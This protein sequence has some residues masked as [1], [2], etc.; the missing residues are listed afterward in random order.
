MD[1]RHENG[2]GNIPS[3]GR[4]PGHFIPLRIFSED[5]TD[6]LRLI[7]RMGR[8]GTTTE[9]ETQK[10]ENRYEPAFFW[11]PIS[12]LAPGPQESAHDLRSC[13]AYKVGG[14]SLLV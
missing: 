12:L 4:F 8:G 5:L 3:L 13:H 6:I 10:I 11:V 1:D 14:R 7:G 2:Y 9:K